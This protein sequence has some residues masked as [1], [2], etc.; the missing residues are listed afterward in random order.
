MD[1][2]NLSWT[3][4]LWSA[5]GS[6]GAAGETPVFGLLKRNG[7]VFVTVVP[8]CSQEELMSIIRGKIL[9]ESTIHTDDWKAYD[10]LILNDYN[11]YRVF[12]HERICLRKIACQQHQVLPELHQTPSCEIQCTNRF[13]IYL[14]FKRNRM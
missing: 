11:H 1:W 3:K 8:N 10:S 13:K 2:V 9:T 14:A 5:A 6:F 4:L 12:H 7:K